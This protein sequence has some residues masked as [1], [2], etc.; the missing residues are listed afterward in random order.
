MS[1]S[2][3][4]RYFTK[5]NNQLRNTTGTTTRSRDFC[6]SHPNLS[7][8]HDQPEKKILSLQL[9]ER[10]VGTVEYEKEGSNTYH[11]IHS[12]I[13]LELQGR[14]YGHVLAKKTFDYIA[15]NNLRMKISCE[16][17]QSA[18]EKNKYKYKQ[19]VE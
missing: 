1:S 3:L 17:L 10:N 6:R 2:Y 18:Y 11:L 12:A 13:P 8:I 5:M 9:D 7:E 15:E 16:F 4:T 19:Y 14:G